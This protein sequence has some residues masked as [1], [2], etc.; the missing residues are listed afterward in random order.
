MNFPN[1]DELSFR[2]VRAFPKAS[3]MGLLCS[4]LSMM[5][6]FSSSTPSSPFPT[7]VRYLAGLRG[8]CDR[9]FLSVHSAGGRAYSLTESLHAKPSQQWL[10]FFCFVTSRKISVVVSKC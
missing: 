1:R 5:E 2:M 6:P 3:R 8:L 7:V 4:T 9:R 10:A